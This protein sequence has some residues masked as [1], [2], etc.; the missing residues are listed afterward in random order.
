LEPLGWFSGYI[1]SQSQQ[2]LDELDGGALVSLVPTE[3]FDRRLLFCDPIAYFPSLA[4]VGLLGG[5]DLDREHITQYIGGDMPF[6]ALDLFFP[7]RSLDPHWHIG[8]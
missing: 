1:Q 3:G 8:F 2:I 5:M 6:T 7:H 4:S